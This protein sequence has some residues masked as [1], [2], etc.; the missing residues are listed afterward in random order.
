LLTSKR[1][2]LAEIG[3][4]SCI[5][6]KAWE[7]PT[8]ESRK[9]IPTERIGHSPVEGSCKLQLLQEGT[10]DIIS[11]ERP[12]D[13][14]QFVLEGRLTTSLMERS[15]MQAKYEWAVLSDV[16][17]EER[18]YSQLRLMMVPGRVLSFNAQDCSVDLT[19]FF[20]K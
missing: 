6:Y 15:N 3:D 9:A 1:T 2:L 4:V 5:K 10:N 20:R 8:P 19:A 12:D 7:H 16:V 14:G 13:L 11:R 18:T 17:I